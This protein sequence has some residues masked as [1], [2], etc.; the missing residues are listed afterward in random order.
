MSEPAKP[1]VAARSDVL[2]SGENHPELLAMFQAEGMVWL[3]PAQMVWREIDGKCVGGFAWTDYDGDTIQAHIVGQPGW[4]NRKILYMSFTYPF[5]QL[6]VKV[7]LAFLPEAR[8]DA[9][10]V[11]LGMGFKELGVIPG[12]N[13][14]LLTLVREDCERWLALPSRGWNG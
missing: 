1:L 6:G 2:R 7:I 9:R 10:R 4:L 5:D 3:K 8:I 14:H 11:A 12:V 13:L